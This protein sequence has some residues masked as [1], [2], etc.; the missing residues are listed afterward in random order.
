MILNMFKILGN[1]KEKLDT[2]SYSGDSRCLI[3]PW[4]QYIG[5]RSKYEEKKFV[6]ALHIIF[7]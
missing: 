5:I 7:D 4:R 2:E 3:P 1:N 6:S